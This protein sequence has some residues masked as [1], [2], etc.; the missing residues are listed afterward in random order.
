MHVCSPFDSE[1]TTRCKHSRCRAKLQNAIPS[2]R[3]FLR[4]TTRCIRSC[5]RAQE[6]YLSVNYKGD[7]PTRNCGRQQDAYIFVVGS[8]FH[9]AAATEP[10][11]R[12]GTFC[13][14]PSSNER[15]SVSRLTLT[16]K[17][18]CDHKMHTRTRHG[19]A[20]LTIKFIS[21][22]GSLALRCCAPCIGRNLTRQ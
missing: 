5:C 15:P 17:C 6:S 16:L 21:C 3:N 22:R 2:A 9:S 4:S 13:G 7:S 10:S 11:P 20:S 14:R 1:P 18:H 19:H 8:S 12:L